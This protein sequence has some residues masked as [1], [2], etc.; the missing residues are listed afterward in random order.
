VRT[1]HPRLRL[2]VGL[3]LPLEVINYW[4]IGYPA[5]T[6]AISRA[7]QNPAV[8]LQW[9]ILHL[10]GILAGDT[11]LLLLFLFWLAGVARRTLRKLSSPMKQAV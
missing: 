3:S 9:Y 8:A 1:K 5:D 10:P 2:A 4:V 11:A 7:A 6:H